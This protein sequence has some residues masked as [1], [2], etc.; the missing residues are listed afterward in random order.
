LII[1]PCHS[2]HSFGM[3]Y[4]F[5]AV[6]IDRDGKVLHVILHMPPNRI[7]RHVFRAHAVIELPTGTIESTE[8]QKGDHI[9][10]AGGL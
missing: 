3:Q 10:I 7:S 5:D 1:H 6:F 9:T 8:T 4:R 2:I